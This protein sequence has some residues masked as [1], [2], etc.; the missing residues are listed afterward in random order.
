MLKVSC[1]VAGC[2]KAAKA[3]KC[4]SRHYDRARALWGPSEAPRRL[5]TSSSEQLRTA[6]GSYETP[7]AGIFK[8][9][10][11]GTAKT[12]APAAAQEA[13]QL[14]DKHILAG[15]QEIINHQAADLEHLR[16]EIIEQQEELTRRKQAETTIEVITAAQQREWDAYAENSQLKEELATRYAQVEELRKQLEELA[17]EEATAPR[18]LRVTRISLGADG[19]PRMTLTGEGV[20]AAAHLIGKMVRL[21][22]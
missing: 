11:G 12:E 7:A 6:L 8:G 1:K 9:K 16:K 4:C 14:E 19:L 5:Y 20:P 13:A 2:P 3:A 21:L 18:L 22:S 15:L 10:R 17:L